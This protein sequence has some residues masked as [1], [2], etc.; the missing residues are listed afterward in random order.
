VN[1]SSI[2]PYPIEREVGRGGMGVV[3]RGQDP[4]LKRTVAIKVLPDAFARDPERLARFERE[5]R[6]LASLTHPNVAGIYG[7]EESEGRRFLVLEFVEGE[8]LAERLQRNNNEFILQ[9]EY[10]PPDTLKDS[11]V[12]LI[13]MNENNELVR[14]DSSVLIDGKTLHLKPK[15]NNSIVKIGNTKLY[16][17][18]SAP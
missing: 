1:V 17:L 12:I 4:R 11:K 10:F 5:A 6:M 7:I 13:K 3:Y 15:G 8:T 2:G 14:I 18:L 16:S 9:S